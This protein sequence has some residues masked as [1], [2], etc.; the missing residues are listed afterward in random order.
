MRASAT[1]RTCAGADRTEPKRDLPLVIV[2]ASNVAF[3]GSHGGQKAR[4]DLLLE[5]VSQVPKA[6][7]ELKVVADA[8]LRHRIDKREEYEGF[9]RDG[10]FLQAPAGRSADQFIVLLVNKR[11]AEGQQVRILTNDLLR[12]H[13]GLEPMR[14]TFLEVSE[15]E[16]VFDPPLGSLNP[17]RTP[18]EPAMV[19]ELGV[20]SEAPALEEGVLGWR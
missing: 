14:I 20:A 13:P 6:G 19:G 18:T 5:V 16:V 12:Q 15:G 9:V 1:D 8:S 7:C 3:G 17:R 11:Q 4:L 2:D 10:F